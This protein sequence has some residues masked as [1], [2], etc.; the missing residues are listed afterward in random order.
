MAQKNL[1]LVSTPPCHRVSGVEVQQAYGI[2]KDEIEPKVV[3]FLFLYPLIGEEIAQDIC[4]M[5][6]VVDTVRNPEGEILRTLR[7]TR[8]C[9]FEVRQVRIG[10]YQ[11]LLRDVQRV[12]VV[13]E[14]ICQ[15]HC[16]VAP[17]TRGHQRLLSLRRG[18]IGDS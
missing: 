9:L 11:C 2:I 14:H 18:L 16:V 4:D 7:Q 3:N 15:Q 10:L 17:A 6:G 8:E 5:S 1:V 13:S 12:N